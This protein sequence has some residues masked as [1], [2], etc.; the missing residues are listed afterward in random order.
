MR[1]LMLEVVAGAAAL[2]HSIPAS[3]PDEMIAP[4]EPIGSYKPL[5]L[6]D[7][8]AGREV[9]VEAIWGEPVRRAAA[10]G[11]RLLEM[12][13]LYLLLRRLTGAGEFAG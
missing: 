6:I 13:A 3:Y 9:E 2:G 12:E 7:F 8:I 1:E 4:T 5:S 10:H 11:V